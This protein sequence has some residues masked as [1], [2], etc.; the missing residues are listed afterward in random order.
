MTEPST[1]QRKK[2]KRRDP[3][4]PKLP[5]SSFMYWMKD[6]RKDHANSGWSVTDMTRNGKISLDHMATHKFCLPQTQQSITVQCDP[7]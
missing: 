4:K 5:L 7:V 2:A 3:D 6:F 1:S